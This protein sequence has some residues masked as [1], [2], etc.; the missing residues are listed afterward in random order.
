MRTFLPV[1]AI[2]LAASPVAAEVGDVV[3]MTIDYSDL[4]LSNPADVAEL[5]ERI[6]S[7]ARKACA[8]EGQY[9]KAFNLIDE[10]CAQD[11]VAAA[12]AELEG[13]NPTVAAI[14]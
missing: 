12:L 9:A 11:L 2:A 3:E 8:H 4:D 13:I 7:N 6:E 1:L 14:N 5:G 10:G